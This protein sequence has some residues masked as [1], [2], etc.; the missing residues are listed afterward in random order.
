MGCHGLELQS[1]CQCYVC[2]SWFVCVAL[3]E[4]LSHYKMD[5]VPRGRCVIINIATFDKGP[6]PLIPR[7][8]SDRDVGQ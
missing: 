3:Y 5:S 7:T 1:E 2:M 6:V 8:G 4:C